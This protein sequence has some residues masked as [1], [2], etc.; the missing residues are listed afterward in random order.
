MVLSETSLTDTHFTL[1]DPWAEPGSDEANPQISA[2]IVVIAG[3]PKEMNF[4]INV[5]AVNAT[6]DVFY[7]GKKLG[8]L[9]LKKYQPAESE[10]IET[11][12]GNEALLRIK[13]HMKDVPL[14]I[15]DDNVFTDVVSALMF[16]GKTVMLK[17]K[18]A[19]DVKLSTVLGEMTI[20][21][22][23]AEGVVPVKR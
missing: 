13:S 9:N 18:A 8:E 21:A 2:N 5:T 16:G 19:V 12:D 10:R 22:M 11:E 1:P 4:S 14:E 17:I 23:P 15:T 7:K 3:L 20:K 6:S